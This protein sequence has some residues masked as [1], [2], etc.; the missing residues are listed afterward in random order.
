MI[1]RSRKNNN[2]EVGGMGGGNVN[3]MQINWEKLTI[4]SEF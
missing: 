4:Q 2:I 1:N 3:N